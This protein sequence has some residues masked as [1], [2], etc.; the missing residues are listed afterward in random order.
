MSDGRI[1]FCF[2]LNGWRDEHHDNY[3]PVSLYRQDSDNPYSD[4]PEDADV[5]IHKAFDALPKDPE[6]YD[7]SDAGAGRWV[8]FDYEALLSGDNTD[9]ILT[10]D[11]RD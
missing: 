8:R 4:T 6:D 10:D 7:E 5:M 1:V 3:H 9:P 2:G 11:P